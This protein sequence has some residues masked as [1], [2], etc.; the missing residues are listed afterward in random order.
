M[1][2][3][4]GNAARKMETPEQAP[5]KAPRKLKEAPRPEPMVSA[6]EE[7]AITKQTT[8]EL[9]GKIRGRRAG[10][11]I[12]APPEEIMRAGEE[13]EEQIKPVSMERIKGDAELRRIYKYVNEESKGARG[14]YLESNK[15]GES[16]FADPGM[17]YVEAL[18]RVK[19]TAGNEGKHKA[20]LEELSRLT[21]DLGLTENALIQTGMEPEDIEYMRSRKSGMETKAM[22]AEAKKILEKEKGSMDIARAQ[23]LVRNADKVWDLVNDTI[24]DPE[25]ATN[26]VFALA[27]FN[28]AVR[29]LDNKKIAAARETVNNL[30]AAAG[31]EG[32]ALIQSVMEKYDE[33]AEVKNPFG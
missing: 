15:P 28:E 7:E 9:L 25:T 11:T 12:Q 19:D 27:R 24:E 10:E 18:T 4:E 13:F 1:P 14:L 22:S 20:A 6:E 8:Q 29:S 16:A 30:N 33:R 3:F 32:N 21:T 17:R 5:A 2:K 26:Y 23:G 31:L